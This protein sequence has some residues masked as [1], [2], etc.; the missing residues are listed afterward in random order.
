MKK[1]FAALLL[2]SLLL[3][4]CSSTYFFSKLDS[5]NPYIQKADNGDFVFENDSLWISHNFNG[6][7]APIQIT[8][9]NKLD[10]PLYVDW[11]K[12][13]LIVQDQAVNYA[14]NTSHITINTS[15]Q[16]YHSP[17]SGTET[18]SV[19]IGSIDGAPSSVDFIP[20]RTKVSKITVR[21]NPNTN[22]LEQLSY[23][24]D[25]MK[26]KDNYVISINRANFSA[27][28]TPFSFTSYIT[29]YTVP[30]KPMVFE[31]DF[32]ISSLIKTNGMLPQNL[33]GDLRQRGDMF[34]VEKFTSSYYNE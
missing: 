3:T 10:I 16:V 14:G 34:F 11:G 9:Y 6:E 4:S 5:G 12:S 20:P 33:P 30:E 21:L 24:K 15:S 32:Y 31:Q 29:V 22:D 7:N 13:A 19:G 27:E 26:D 2:V 18:R 23:T 8:V 1:T 28:D 17:T 25:K